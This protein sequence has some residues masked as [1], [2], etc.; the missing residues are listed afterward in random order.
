MK[1]ARLLL[2]VRVVVIAGVMLAV[3]AWLQQ[4]HLA[5]VEQEHALIALVILGYL[6]FWMTQGRRR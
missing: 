3:V 1:H 2:T 6:A 5:P 4:H